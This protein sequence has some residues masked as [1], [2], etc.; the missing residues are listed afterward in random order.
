VL[1]SSQLCGVGSGAHCGAGVCCRHVVFV[2]VM[3]GGITCEW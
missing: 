3:P 2:C 1:H